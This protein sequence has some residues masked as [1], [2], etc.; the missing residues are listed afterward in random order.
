PLFSPTPF[1]LNSQFRLNLATRVDARSATMFAIP[2]NAMQTKN[3]S[4]PPVVFAIAAGA[5]VPG[6]TS[7]AAAHNA[8]KHATHK[9]PTAAVPVAAPLAD[10]IVVVG[11]AP[12]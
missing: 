1:G 8:A 9:K 2:M 12:A 3:F 11:S 4:L 5:L 7:F 6:S 10:Q